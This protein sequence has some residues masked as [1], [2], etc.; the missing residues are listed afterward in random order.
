L[1]RNM[2]VQNLWTDRKAAVAVEFVLIS[3]ALFLFLFFLSDLV[4]RQAMIGKLDRVSY[5]VSGVLRERIQLFEGREELQ[6]NDID[7]ALGLAKRMLKDM[8]ESADLSQ[9]QMVVEEL[10]FDDPV[11]LGDT[12]K[13]IKIYKSWRSGS[14]K[15]QCSPPQPLNQLTQLTPKGSYGRWVPLYQVTVCL[16]TISWFTRLTSTEQT[17]T[18]SSFAIVMLR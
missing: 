9:L 17:P 16:P 14:G 12:S 11:R 13:V 1:F 3:I 18:M 5:S 7:A 6:Q 10:H 15:A 4:L 8:T 2:N